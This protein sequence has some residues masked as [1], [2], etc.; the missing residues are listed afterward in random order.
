MKVARK[1]S[2][3]SRAMHEAMTVD[4]L[5][6][7]Y[8][9]M[10]V[11][12]LS[13]VPALRPPAASWRIAFQR[14]RYACFPAGPALERRAPA[15]GDRPDARG[16]FEPAGPRDRPAALSACMRATSSP[17][18]RESWP[19]RRF[20]SMPRLRAPGERSRSRMPRTRC[21]CTARTARST[22]RA[23]GV[24][25]TV[26]PR[27]R[28]A[29]RDRGRARGRRPS[30]RQRGRCR[31]GRRASILVGRARAKLREHGVGRQFPARPRRRGSRRAWRLADI[32]DGLP[33]VYAATREAFVAQMLNLDVLDAIS[34]TKGCYTGRTEIV[35]RPNPASRPHQAADVPAAAPRKAPGTWVSRCGSRAGMQAGWSTSPRAVPASRRSP[36]SASSRRRPPHRRTM[37]PASRP[38]RSAPGSCRCRTS[39][40]P[41]R[42]QEGRPVPFGRAPL[43]VPLRLGKSYAG[44]ATR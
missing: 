2:S 33:Q 8:P 9:Y 34:F 16:L 37:R 25:A 41:A 10:Y 7:K 36:F 12:P 24:K 4:K 6:K 22:P 43:S 3:P 14:P 11:V 44:T 5:V 39:L 15:R 42:R 21:R 31:R 29:R 23:L 40:R 32:R 26:G 38:R 13:F 28:R 1:R 18:C 17:S 35:P 20:E 27:A 30:R 19:P